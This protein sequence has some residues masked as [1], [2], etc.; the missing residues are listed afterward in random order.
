MNE[1]YWLGR[2]S[3]RDNVCNA[4]CSRCQ[5]E[6]TEVLKFKQA[7]LLTNARNTFLNKPLQLTPDKSVPF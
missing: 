7:G 4:F 6:V 5:D 3:D 1:G 2:L